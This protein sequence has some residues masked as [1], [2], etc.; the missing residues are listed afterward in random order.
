MKS[1]LFCIVILFFLFAQQDL[2]AQNVK[3]AFERVVYKRWDKFRPWWWFNIAYKKYDNEDR[4]NILQ[5]APIFL[6]TSITKDY[7]ESQKKSIDTI[8]RVKVLDAMDRVVTKRWILFDE[9]KAAE[10]VLR[11]TR[12]L[13]EGANLGWSFQEQLVLGQRFLSL[14]TDIDTL[15]KSFISD[16]D[17][18][19]EIHAIIKKLEEFERFLDFYILAQNI[20]NLQQTPIQDE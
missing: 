8:F 19:L 7:T 4:R 11:I 15:L 9:Q 3:H 13:G 17:K 6:E 10:I 20:N 18:S 16:A 5:L 1:K 2:Q 12:K 14:R